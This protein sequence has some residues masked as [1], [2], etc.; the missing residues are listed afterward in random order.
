MLVYFG[1][2]CDA[3]AVVN[4]MLCMCQYDACTH[5]E[6]PL[7]ITL[8]DKVTR[9]GPVESHII[10]RMVVRLPVVDARESESSSGSG[11]T[12]EQRAFTVCARCQ[13]ILCNPCMVDKHSLLVF[14]RKHGTSVSYI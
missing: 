11:K 2:M 9:A 13:T 4:L 1:A 12:S 6:K 5:V 10:K 3:P 7:W 8:S 14:R